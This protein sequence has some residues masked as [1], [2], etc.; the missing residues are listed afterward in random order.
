M[1]LINFCC[2]EKTLSEERKALQKSVDAALVK[3][4]AKT[5]LLKEYLSASFSLKKGDRVHDMNF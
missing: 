4:I 2:Q 5:P 3:A 1:Y